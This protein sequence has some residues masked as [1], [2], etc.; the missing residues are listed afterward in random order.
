MRSFSGWDSRECRS[1]SSG[2]VLYVL[3]CGGVQTVV[4]RIVIGQDLHA[5]PMISGVH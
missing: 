3:G 1:W 4:R 5:V 2:I